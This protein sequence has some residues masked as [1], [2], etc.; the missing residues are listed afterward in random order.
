[1]KRSL[2]IWLGLVALVFSLAHAQTPTGRIHGQVIGPTG[3]PV[4]RG[5]TVSLST[6][7]GFT[8]LFTFPVSS[9]GEYGGYAPAG[10][11]D[12]VYRMADTPPNK[13]IDIYK[14]VTIVSGGDVVQ[15]IDM[16]RQSF[17]DAL[18]PEQREE[19]EKVKEQNAEAIRANQIIR[20]LNADIVSVNQDLR[21][22]DVAH[23]TAMQ[24]LGVSDTTDAVKA[25][26]AE[27]RTAKYTE[28]ETLMMKDTALRPG[29]SILWLDLGQAKIGLKKYDEGETDLRNALQI[30][31]AKQ[32][33]NPAIIGGADSGLGTLYAEQGKVPAANSAFDEAARANPGS[34][35]LYLKNEAVIFYQEGN[36]VAQVA[37]ADEAIQA[38][39]NQP[40]SY[41]LKGQ[42]LLQQAHTDPKTGRI[43]AP[44][45]CL[46]AYQK[47]L[48]L[49]PNGPYSAEVKGALQGFGL[50]IDPSES[51]GAKSN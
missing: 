12:V 10:T 45:G 37:A 23:S 15:N 28:I 24:E 17:I 8:S 32:S 25:R 19:L 47:Y 27:I 14:G 46:E 11:Y 41:Y 4:T 18:T 44:A 13:M 39:P 36:P 20:V 42:G 38:D 34:A 35:A 30:E 21:D 2:S 51:A 29:E 9:T 43:V 7:G 31:S 16:S 6:D 40:V 33:P 3:M 5:G 26:E 48:Q 50:K 22:A 1:M 49:A